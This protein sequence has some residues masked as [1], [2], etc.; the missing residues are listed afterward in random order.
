MFLKATLIFPQQKVELNSWALDPYQ[1]SISVK[2]LCRKEWSSLQFVDLPIG[3]TPACQLAHARQA[4]D[5][6]H[7]HP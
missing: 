4:H 3:Q 6:Q 2:V 5:Y 1:S 7:A